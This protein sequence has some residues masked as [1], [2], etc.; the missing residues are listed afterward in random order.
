MPMDMP[1]A[2]VMNPP[3]HIAGVPEC[4]ILSPQEAQVAFERLR[5]RLPGTAFASA[6]PSQVCGLVRVQLQ[7]GSVAYTDPTGRYFLLALALDTHRGEPADLS[8]E[9]EEAIDAR[10]QFPADPAPGV[11]LPVEPRDDE[12]RQSKAISTKN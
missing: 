8:E 4:R 5:K 7:R 12:P 10:S 1:P 2:A 3:A 9:I 6:A 11:M